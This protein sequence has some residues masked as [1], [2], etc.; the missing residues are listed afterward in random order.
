MYIYDVGCR[1]DGFY[2]VIIH[3]MYCTFL[4]LCSSLYL[5]YSFYTS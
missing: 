5:V 4:G 2:A 1:F 3:A